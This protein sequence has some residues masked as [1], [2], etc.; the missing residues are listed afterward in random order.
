MALKT[1]IVGIL[2]LTP[3]SFSDGGE[4]AEGSALTH[5]GQLLEDG[6]D[7]IDIG[8][9]STRPGA[10]ALSPEA[11]WQRL[12]K[13]LR[14]ARKEF[15]DVVLS[16]DTRH[17]ATASKALAL[18]VDWINDVS[19][20]SP[21]VLAVVVGSA[22]RYVLMHSLTIPADLKM[23]LPE[24]A[25]PVAAVL[26]WAALRTADCQQAGIKK[27]RLILDPGIGFGKSARQSWELVRRVAE[28]KESGFNWLIGHSR[29][30]FLSAVGKRD[31]KDRDLETHLLSVQLALAGADYLRVHDVA[32]TRR[33]LAVASMLEG[34]G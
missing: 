24:N 29:K 32:G 16:L 6:A 5:I 9:E 23:V 7:I 10:V 15:P 18:G 11:E 3:D 12:E 26:E 27:E 30:S 31:A 22:C 21:D 2:N 14:A 4:V 1:K 33:A 34:E 13:T 25:D 20:G 8:A 28:L 19:G 17:A